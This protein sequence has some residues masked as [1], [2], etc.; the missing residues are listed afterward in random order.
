MR[1][2][3][4]FAA[5]SMMLSFLMSALNNKPQTEYITNIGKINTEYFNYVIF[6]LHVL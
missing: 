5:S 2:S 4:T 1:I 6:G 3:N